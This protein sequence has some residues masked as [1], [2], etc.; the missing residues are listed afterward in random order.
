MHHRLQLDLKWFSTKTFDLDATLST[1]IV[2]I[3][4]S[5]ELILV[6]NYVLIVYDD[7]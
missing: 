3:I 6:A 4:I 2:L 1:L 7:L 5:S